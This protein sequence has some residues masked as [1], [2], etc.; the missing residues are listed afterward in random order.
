MLQSRPIIWE[1]LREKVIFWLETLT[2][3]S[4]VSG[5]ILVMTFSLFV[6]FVFYTLLAIVN[7]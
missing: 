1:T 4:L 3:E 7:G 6:F 2:Y 5:V